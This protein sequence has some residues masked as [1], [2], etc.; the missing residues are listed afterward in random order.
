MAD[1]DFGAVDI[2]FLLLENIFRMEHN[3]SDLKNLFLKNTVQV[4]KNLF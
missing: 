2:F 1:R 4:G 3:F